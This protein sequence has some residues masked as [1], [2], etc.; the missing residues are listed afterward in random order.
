MSSDEDEDLQAAIRASLE[1]TRSNLPETS[2]SNIEQPSD[3]TQST[4]AQGRVY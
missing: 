1:P 3:I 4:V 2:R